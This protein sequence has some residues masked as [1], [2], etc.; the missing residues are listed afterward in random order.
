MRAKHFA[1]W[2]QEALTCRIAATRL[3]AML[4]SVSSVHALLASALAVLAVTLS[5]CTIVKTAGEVPV[6][7][8]RAVTPGT[9][10]K[11]GTD[12]VIVQQAMLRFGDEFLARMVTGID[13]V[14][15]VTNVFDPVQVLE[16]RIAIG[17]ETCAI[18]SGPNAVANLLDMTIFVTAARMSVED[19]WEPKVF[20]PAGRPLLENCRGAET[21]VWQLAS[22]VLKPE[23]QAELR[24]AIEVWHR[25]NPLPRNVLGVRAVGLASE[26]ARAMHTDQT[27]S[28]S[29]FNLLRLDPL[30]S[31]DPA[32]REL[33]QTRLFAERALYVM[34]KMPT[35]VRWQ[36]E[37]LSLKTMDL[38]TVRQLVTNSTELA[39]SVERFAVAAEKL[40]AQVS[41]EREEILKAL[42][43]QEKSLTPLV[44]EVRQTL[45]AGAQMS[46]S[47]NTTLGTFDTVLKDLGLGDTNSAASPDTN[48]QPFRI[49]DYRQT[50]A[51]LEA[52]AQQL[53]KLLVTFDQTLAST[54]LSQLSAQ[55]GPAV[56][57]AEAGGKQI[58][59][60]A[61][62]KALVLLAIVLGGVLL[63]RFVS[64]RLTLAGRPKADSR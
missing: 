54:N 23:Q 22:T 41:A 44:N 63:Y 3:A 51:Q 33:A 10:D 14:Q 16:W 24:Q 52:T 49:E 40:P 61:F 1:S 6:Q 18:A 15:R 21:Q 2:S 46:T 43:A 55:V 34:Q 19:Y 5:G 25:E 32:T 45:T 59:D 13:L 28:G 53:T 4:R 47:L 31:L 27:S 38:P 7:T 57:Q 58:V 48:S 37:L 30:S 50:A 11:P 56:Q 17:T 36:T 29:V 26:V 8:L 42:Q 60:Y 9:K 20:G 12:P 64:A 62:R 35:L 39:S